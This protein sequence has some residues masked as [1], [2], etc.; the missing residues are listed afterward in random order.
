MPQMASVLIKP[1]ADWVTRDVEACGHCSEPV[2]GAGPPPHSQKL[3]YF[4]L[5]TEKGTNVRVLW[6]CLGIAFFLLFHSDQSLT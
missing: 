6:F 4:P 2:Q 1:T 3:T 5:G